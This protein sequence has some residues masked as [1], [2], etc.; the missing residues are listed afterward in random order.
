MGLIRDITMRK[1]AESVLKQKMDELERF[2]DLT[3][4]RELVMIK[5]KK[6]INELLKLAGKEEK[7][8]IVA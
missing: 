1:Q 8:T 3:V 6:E 4:G 2:N 7:Y 5:L